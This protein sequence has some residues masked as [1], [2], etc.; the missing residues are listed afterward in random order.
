M[1]MATPDTIFGKRHVSA[2]AGQAEEAVVPA[3]SMQCSAASIPESSTGPPRKD[4]FT[5]EKGT[6]WE[7][8]SGRRSLRQLA[9]ASAVKSTMSPTPSKSEKPDTCIVWKSAT[10]RA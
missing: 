6:V 5:S 3:A 2:S 8:V 1:F 4:I 7:G 10:S 9:P